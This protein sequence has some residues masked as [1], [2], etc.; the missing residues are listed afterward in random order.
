MSG[1]VFKASHVLAHLAHDEFSSIF[2]IG[3]SNLLMIIELRP[4]GFGATFFTS[5]LWSL[6]KQIITSPHLE[7][8][9]SKR[10]RHLGL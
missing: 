2:P 4:F 7:L 3:M 10:N 5:V 1:M 9:P 8:A 6:Y